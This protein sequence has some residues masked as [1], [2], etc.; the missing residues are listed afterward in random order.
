MPAVLSIALLATFALA[1]LASPVVGVRRSD[2]ALL[3]LPAGLTFVILLDEVYKL[4]SR[5]GQAAGIQGRYLYSWIVP[6]LVV[7]VLGVAALARLI[8]RRVPA[9]TSREAGTDRADRVVLVL[10]AAFGILYTVASLG[11]GVSYAFGEDRWS[12]PLRALP[13]IAAWAPIP[14]AG[15]TAIVA[16]FA[17]ALL[18]GIVALLRTRRYAPA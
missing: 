1:L 12:N 4:T 11:R 14:A 2:V 9:L 8:G 16:L 17:A 13:H 18:L 3:L 5:T 15:T 6:L 10:V 7:S